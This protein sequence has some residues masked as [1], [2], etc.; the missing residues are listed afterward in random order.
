MNDALTGSLI[1]YGGQLPP[2]PMLNPRR[3]WMT[4]FRHS[5]RRIFYCG[6]VVVALRSDKTP[7]GE[8]DAQES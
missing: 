1:P 4:G 3:H 7:K 2:N 8:R 5:S 6:T